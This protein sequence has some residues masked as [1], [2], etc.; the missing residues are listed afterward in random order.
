MPRIDDTKFDL[1]NIYLAGP[2]EIRRACGPLV[3]I[4]PNNTLLFTHFSVKEFLVVDSR[5]K[6]SESLHKDKPVVTECLILDPL[7]AHQ[8]ILYISSKYT[9][10]DITT[11]P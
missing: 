11:L 10:I 8:S 4:T 1:T 5:T 2:E 9:S 3:E 6:R 7:Q